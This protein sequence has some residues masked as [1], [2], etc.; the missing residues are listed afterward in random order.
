MIFILSLYGI[1]PPVSSVKIF[2]ILEFSTI[3]RD[4]TERKKT[5]Y[6]L[7]ES[8]ERYRLLVENSTEMIYKTDMYGNYTYVNQVFIKNSDY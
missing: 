7:Q 8:E 6:E 4:I 3:S 2:L 1:F 5:E